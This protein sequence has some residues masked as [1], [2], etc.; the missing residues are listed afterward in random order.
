VQPSYSYGFVG[1]L[2]LM[3]GVTPKPNRIDF[4][5]GVC[6]ETLETIRDKA[7]LEKFRY[8]PASEEASRR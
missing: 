1:I 8:G 4:K 7:S 5:C 3:F 2:G 6:G